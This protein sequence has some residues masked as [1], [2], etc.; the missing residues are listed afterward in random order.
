MPSL[1]HFASCQDRTQNKQPDPERK[2]QNRTRGRTERFPSL[3]PFGFNKSHKPHAVA[4]GGRTETGFNSLGFLVMSGA[5]ALLTSCLLISL[6]EKVPFWWTSRVSDHSVLLRRLG[7]VGAAALLQGF[8][9][10]TPGDRPSPR[11]EAWRVWPKRR[12]A[13]FF[14]GEM[15]FASEVTRPSG[16]TRFVQGSCGRGGNKC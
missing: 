7:G 1:V 16:R 9:W 4:S 14:T 5:P 8:C 6:V 2:N 10:G 15:R 3:W 12:T 13:P 11:N